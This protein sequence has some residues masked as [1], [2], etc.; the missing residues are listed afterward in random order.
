MVVVVTTLGGAVG[1]VETVVVTPVV[2]VEVEFSVVV[3][4]ARV[5]VLVVVDVVMFVVVSAVVPVVVAEV[6][7]AN[8]SL[9][10]SFSSFLHETALSV[11]IRHKT[12]VTVLL[13]RFILMTFPLF[14][15]ISFV[16]KKVCTKIHI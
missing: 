4:V 10:F 1:A 3:V 8:A 6:T 15:I 13:K 14:K 2:V 7:G 16:L 9:S 11:N 12:A 5:V